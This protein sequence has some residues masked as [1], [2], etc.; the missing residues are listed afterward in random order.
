MELN[1]KNCRNILINNFGFKLVEDPI[2]GPVIEMDPLN[3]YLY[4]LIEKSPYLVDETRFFS[5]FGKTD[6]LF[7][8]ACS[9]R[10]L[11]GVF[12]HIYDNNFCI[13]NSPLKHNERFHKIFTGPKYIIFY[14]LADS[15][16]EQ[17]ILNSIYQKIKKKG[18]SPS[19]YL[20]TLILKEYRGYKMEHFCEYVIC[21]YLREQGFIT[22]NQ[23]KLSHS[24][25]KPD[26]GAFMIQKLQEKLKKERFSEGGC[27]LIELACLRLFGKKIKVT[28]KNFE[29][30]LLR[31]GDAKTSA[32]SA[33]E[34]LKKYL[35]TGFFNNAFEVI[36]LVSKPK[37]SFGLYFFNS[38]HKIEYKEEDIKDSHEKEQEDYLE[39]IINNAKI[40]LLINLNED[41][42]EKAMKER[43]FG[44][45][46]PKNF[47]NFVRKMNINEIIEIVNGVL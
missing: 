18:G 10:L 17:E 30:I 9:Y 43:G 36:P 15:S 13:W 26:V 6:R 27:F 19:G 23:L 37:R 2:V 35:S 8:K 12:D 11:S 33:V 14:E 40:Y 34:Q 16:K 7:D 21:K 42:I 20:V 1:A 5:P 3:A 29:D 44:E 24:K 45:W 39:W 41:E 28:Q 22:Q 31:V 32:T 47:I 38:N 46:N 25:G 4:S